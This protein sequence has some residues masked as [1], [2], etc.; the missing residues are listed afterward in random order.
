MGV[1]Q[2]HL[3]LFGEVKK[4]IPY[5][6]KMTNKKQKIIIYIDGFNLYYGVRSLG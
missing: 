5:F 2:T 4:I 6:K 3:S 1:G